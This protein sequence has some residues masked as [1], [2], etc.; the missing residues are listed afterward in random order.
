MKEFSGQCVECSELED[1]VAK[2]KGVSGQRRG[3]DAGHRRPSFREELLEL[4]VTVTQ[5]NNRSH[6]MVPK[7]F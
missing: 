7:A 4:G 3:T 2:A 1:A 6:Y 5:H